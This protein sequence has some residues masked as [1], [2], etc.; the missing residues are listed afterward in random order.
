MQT[1]YKG[2]EDHKRLGSFNLAPPQLKTSHLLHEE[3]SEEK[4]N[5]LDVS[6]DEELNSPELNLLDKK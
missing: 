5:H 4:S 3:I 6:L 1:N 2:F